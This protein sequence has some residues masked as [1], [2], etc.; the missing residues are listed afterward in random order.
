MQHTPIESIPNL[1]AQ[2]RHYT[3]GRRLYYSSSSPEA[4]V[5][6]LSGGTR[7]NAR[8]DLFLKTAPSGTLPHE[9]RML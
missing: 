7:E 4:R 5:Y 2:L 6:S 3:A 9:S 8:P 1:P